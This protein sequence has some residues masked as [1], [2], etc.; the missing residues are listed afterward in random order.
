MR[1]KVKG[2]TL[3]ELL[4]VLLIAAVLIGIA[5]PSYLTYVRKSRRSDATSTLLAMQLAEEKYRYSNTSYGNLTQV[6]GGIAISPGGYYALSITNTSATSYTV[7]AT[8][9]GDQSNDSQNGTSCST[10]RIVVSNGNQ[11]LSPT[12]CWQ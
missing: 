3:I 1:C 9:Q 5:Y 8:G 11:T 6:W 12:N 7:T 10:M 2:F 4:I